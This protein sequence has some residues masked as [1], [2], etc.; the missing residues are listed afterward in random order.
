[1]LA[2]NKGEWSELYALFKIFCDRNIS[3]ADE[4]LNPIEGQFYTFLKILRR[5][6]VGQKLEYNLETEHRVKLLDASGFEIKSI[7][8]EDLGQKTQTILRKIIEAQ[9]SSFSIPEAEDLMGEYMLESVKAS[10]AKKSD[11]TAVILDKIDN[12]APE[13]GFS[14]KSQIGH[15]STLLNSSMHTNFIYDVK[16]LDRNID[17]INSIGGKSKVRDRIKAIVSAG[18]KIE[19]NSVSS[20]CFD[21]NMQYMDSR[22]PHLIAGMLLRYYLGEG[23]L[24]A[25][26]CKRT[27][28][29]PDWETSHMVYKVKG[30]LRAV[31]LG[32]VPSTPWSTL[33]QTY[34]GYL[35]VKEDGI[36]CYHLYNDDQFRNY[37]FRNTCFD[38]PS[39]TRYNFG[40][41]YFEDGQTKLKLNLQI[42]F[43]K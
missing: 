42:R 17:D 9:G 6:G 8:T 20:E 43:L 11:I 18:A 3:A 38:T 15:P 41:L 36:V 24:I 1:M 25:E 34:G 28:L 4:D 33:L 29:S 22:F 19:F 26:L 13:I 35:V 23:K 12:T 16:E 21:N 31:A 32:M 37:L 14:I 40:K 5:N 39:T 2:A 27:T 10:S 7:N 30:F